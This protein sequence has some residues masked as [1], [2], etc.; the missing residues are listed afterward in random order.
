MLLVLEIRNF[1]DRCGLNYNKLYHQKSNFRLLS[2]QNFLQYQII[3]YEGLLTLSAITVGF[4]SLTNLNRGYS[5]M[6]RKPL[7]YVKK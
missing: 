4:S 1:T 3:N 2:I 7:K 5:L 6:D